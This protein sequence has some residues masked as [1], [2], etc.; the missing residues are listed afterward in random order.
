M[1]RGDIPVFLLT[2]AHRPKPSGPGTSLNT[3]FLDRGINRFA[4]LIK[5]T[6]AQWDMAHKEGL[7]QK[8]DARVKVLFLLFFVV[9]VSIK[10]LI[11]PETLI[12][13]F[14]LIL[15]LLSRLNLVSFYGKVLF[16]GFLFGFLVALPSCLNIIVR[17]DVLIP[18]VHLSQSYQFWI[19]HIPQTIGITRQGLYGVFMLTLRVVNSLS[20][21]LLVIYTTPFPEIIKALKGLRVPDTFLMIITLSYKYIFIFARTLEDIHLAKKSKVVEVDTAEAR[22]WVVGRMAFLL[23]KTR[24]RCEDVFYAMLARG[25]TGDVALYG[26]GRM[27]TKDVWAGA[28]LLSIGIAFIV[29]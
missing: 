29:I 18:L 14:I 3:A 4:A 23:R 11:L 15:V 5:T 13:F 10:T 21:S 22:N 25:F 20:L 2:G 28:L 19:Y 8:L 12:G 6:Y 9:I 26:C 16:F 7:F 24:L 1:K 17:G 27:K